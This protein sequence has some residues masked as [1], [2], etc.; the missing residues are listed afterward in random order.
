MNSNLSGKIE[1]FLPILILNSC[2]M[3]TWTFHKTSRRIASNRK[4]HSGREV[5]IL[6]LLF[7]QETNLLQLD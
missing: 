2:Q 4:F 3:V 5:E 6:K 7:D 1:Q